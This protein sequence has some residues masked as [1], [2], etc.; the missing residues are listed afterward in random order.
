MVTLL[1]PAAEAATMTFWKS[2]SQVL[3]GQDVLTFT[4]AGTGISMTVSGGTHS[5]GA[6]A[7]AP[8]ATETPCGTCIAQH[9]NGISIDRGGSD[10]HELDGSGPDE[11]IRLTFSE[12]VLLTDVW[13]NAAG[14][15]DEWDMSV[16]N[17]DFG[18]NGAFGSDLIENLIDS[19]I[20]A[21]PSDDDRADF[22]S[23]GG[24]IMGTVFTFYTD[25][26]N[27]DYKLA[28]LKFNQIAQVPL[29]AALPL[30]AGGLGVLGFVGWRRKRA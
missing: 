26:N 12:K 13:F 3:W 5:G 18:V 9:R 11:F 27:D 10:S 19:D 8:F 22:V 2:G 6:G 20:A 23:N 25:D 21:T 1:A 28:A 14:N 17:V 7:N 24:A 29:P 4:D 16:D 15:G 30:L